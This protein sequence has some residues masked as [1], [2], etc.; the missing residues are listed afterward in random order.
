MANKVKQ[1]RY[2]NE[3]NENNSP[4]NG[5]MTDFIT[6]DVFNAVTPILQLGVQTIP[7][8]KVVFNEATDYVII[9]ST[10]IFELDLK[11][12][13]FI[14]RLQFQKETM[15]LIRDNDSAFLIVDVIYEDG[16]G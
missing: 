10:G 12:Q 14:S 5:T 1:F 9:G 16:E 2:Y 11:G 7:G 15:E 6:G 4:V 8:A 13:T 3:G